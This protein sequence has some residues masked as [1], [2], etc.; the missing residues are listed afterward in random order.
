MFHLRA[1]EDEVGRV[2][3]L[4]RGLWPPTAKPTSMP[5]GHTAGSDRHLVADL[6]DRPLAQ[7]LYFRKLLETLEPAPLG[8]VFT[9]L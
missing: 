4:A 7:T 5:F 6:V 9:K 8:A 3:Q 2:E 1:E